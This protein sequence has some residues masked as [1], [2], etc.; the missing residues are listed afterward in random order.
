MDYRQILYA[1]ILLLGFA[2]YSVGIKQMLMG[3]YSPS[4]FSRVIWLL[5]A[6]NSF[7]GVVISKSTNASILLAGIFLVGNAAI[8]LA[9]FW[10]GS[11]EFGKLEIFCLALLLVS[12]FVWILFDS[13][14]INLG[15]SLLAHFVGALPT[16]KRVWLHPKSE[17]TL[18]WFYFFGASALSIFASS[19]S[20]VK[21]VIFPLYFTLFDG[22]LFLLSLRK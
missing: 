14:L 5:L 12:C 15:I 21:T 3:K 2:S 18:F 7:A 16:Y 20:T 10:K 17:S 19:D 1:I 22:S 11:K 13:P 6:I 4:V 9:S 8:C